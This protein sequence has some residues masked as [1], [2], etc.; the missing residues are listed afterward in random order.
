MKSK[1]TIVFSWFLVVL[2][3]IIIFNF[4]G[5]PAQQSSEVSEDVVVQILDIV[6]DKEDITPPVVQKFQFP[7]RKLAHFSIYMLL[8]FCMIS[9]FEKTFKIKKYLNIIFSILASTVYAITDE[10]HQSFSFNRGPSFVDVLIDTSGAIAGTF[11]F[12]LLMHLYK[13]FILNKSRASL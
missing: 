11:I 10:I 2:T 1:L 8:G 12:I 4:S 5:Q 9:A 7:V 13:K 6:M 3:M